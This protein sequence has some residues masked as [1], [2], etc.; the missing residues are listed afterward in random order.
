M[1]QWKVTSTLSQELKFSITYLKSDNNNVMMTF[2][3]LRYVAQT[4]GQE[5]EETNGATGTI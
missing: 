3:A 1:A 2:F 5:D 4:C